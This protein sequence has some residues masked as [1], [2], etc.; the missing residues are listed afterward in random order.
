MPIRTHSH[1]L[2]LLPVLMMLAM[3][4]CV[5]GTSERDRKP[6]PDTL[7]VGTLYSP[8]SFF[9]LH[10]D[11]L[12]YD[13]DRI[14]DFA[15]SKGINLK[16]VV[17]R[18]IT[19]LIRLLQAD[20]VQVLAYEIP[21]TAE[22]KQ[23]VHSCGAVNETFQVLIQPTGDSLITD[24]T[25]LIGRDIY[26]ERGTK[27]ESRLRNLDSELGGGIKIHS[28][29][30][31]TLMPEDL[32]E[33]VSKKE[34]P[35]TI[36]DSDI[37]QL[38]HTYF[39]DIDISL[40][41]SFAQ[42][43]AWAVNLN[44]KWLGD[45][46]DA[47]A[48]SRNA[49]AYSKVALQR[50]FELSKS[51]QKQLADTMPVTPEGALSPFDEIF[52]KYGKQSNI[53]WRLLAAISYV[54][55]RFDPRVVSWAGARGIMQ[56][57]PKTA[58]AYGVEMDQIT[59]PEASVQAAVKSLLDLYAL[60][61]PRI[62][63]EAQRTKFVLASYNAGMG[64]VLDA[65]ELAKKYELDP[66]VWEGNVEEAILWKSNPQ[67]YNDPVCR[68]GYCRGKETVN[69]VVDVEQRY[70]YYLNNFEE[71]DEKEEKAYKGKKRKHHSKH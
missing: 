46:I 40:R 14:C 57:M 71:K 65:I 39:D 45:S 33:M 25:Q 19:H 12:G 8:T 62:E 5:N 63:N 35:L 32:I 52:Q 9:I 49:Q 70:N 30:P 2:L 23:Q 10:D 42:R 18:N 24:V 16:W 58:K 29:T 22:Y 66:Q 15:R 13:H 1:L 27:Y 47:W 21:I 60:F 6:L 54:E 7:I 34:I 67:Y 53:D 4:G 37:A 31:D 38:N 20:S 41:V 51:E 26:V 17:A 43:S 55:S 3:M 61:E 11:T 36:V 68:S 59:D 28:L 69:Y 48:K 56:L 50:Y 44:N 64:H